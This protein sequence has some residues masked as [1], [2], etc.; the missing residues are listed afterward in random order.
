MLALSVFGGIGA[1]ALNAAPGTL[2]AILPVWA[3]VLWGGSLTLGSAMA[4]F[5]MLFQTLNGIVVE[6]VGSVMV[7]AATIFY[8]VIAFYIVGFSAIQVVGLVLAWGLACF[9]RWGQL[10][11]LIAASYR[12]AV[13][14]GRI[15]E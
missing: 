3:I 2:D 10:Q 13:A 11:A 12:K 5:G 14:E 7:G 9:V 6:Q 8:S 1:L 4:L 15:H